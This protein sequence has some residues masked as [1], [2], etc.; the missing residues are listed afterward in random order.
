MS[1]R[2]ALYDALAAVTVCD[3]AWWQKYGPAACSPLARLDFRAD[4][5]AVVADLRRPTKRM[6]TGIYSAA[7]LR[8]PSP[9]E[10]LEALHTRA[11]WP[12]AV[13]GDGAVRWWCSVCEGRG[14]VGGVWIGEDYADADVCSNC[15][16]EDPSSTGGYAVNGWTPE[17]SSIPALVAAASLGASALLRAAS[18]AEDIARAAGHPKARIVWRVMT[19]AAIEDHHNR[20]GIAADAHDPATAFSREVAAEMYLGG[21][22]A[23]VAAPWEA[24]L[25]NDATSVVLA[26][27]ALYA[28]ARHEDGTATGVHLV[29]IDAGAVTLAC[30]ALP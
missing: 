15:A 21:R 2:V 24:P 11:L 7:G 27:D 14:C 8:Y 1:A 12:F 9:A 4:E 3:V 13:E 25:G 20:T 29:G 19:R 23:H 28:L 17:P 22:P 5:V 6:R 16:V 26:W 10:A 18:L 30:E